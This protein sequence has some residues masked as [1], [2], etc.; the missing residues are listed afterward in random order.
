MYH[1]RSFVEGCFNPAI[2]SVSHQG[3][4]SREGQ[5]NPKRSYIFAF[6]AV[7]NAHPPRP[8]GESMTKSAKYFSLN[9][10]RP[11]GVNPA[12]MCPPVLISAVKKFVVPVFQPC[13]K[14]TVRRDRV[15]PYGKICPPAARSIPTG[16]IQAE[17]REMLLSLFGYQ[18]IHNWTSYRP[19]TGTFNAA[20]A[21]PRNLASYSIASSRIFQKSRTSP[22]KVALGPAKHA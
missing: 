6:F 15:P 20:G 12:A 14:P 19:C 1:A 2:Y 11:S 5:T 10:V 22:C 9:T 7:P 3:N 4:P 8:F 21:E 17:V 18:Q 13:A 16:R